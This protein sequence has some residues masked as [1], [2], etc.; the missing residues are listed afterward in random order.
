MEP[1]KRKRMKKCF[2]LLLALILIVSIVAPIDAKSTYP[3]SCALNDEVFSFIREGEGL[4]VPEQVIAKASSKEHA[5]EIAEAYGLIFESYAWGI[6]VF[7]VEDA[8]QAVFHSYRIRREDL[9]VLSLNWIYTTMDD[10]EDIIEEDTRGELR[11]SLSHTGKGHESLQ[12]PFVPLHQ[13][14]L[15]ET[16]ETKVQ[17]Y[18]WQGRFEELQRELSYEAP[19]RVSL[20]LSHWQHDIMD[21]HRAWELSRGEGVIVAVIDTGIDIDHPSFEGRILESSFN[22]HTGEIGLQGVRD[23][24]GHGTHVTG[25]LA[26]A[27]VSPDYIS[28]VAT[29]AYIMSIK[30]NLPGTGYFMTSDLLRSINYAVANGADIINMSL[31][32][33]GWFEYYYHH[34]MH[35]GI[36]NAV[37]NGITVVAAAGNSRFN[38]VSFP[39]AFPEVIA[40]SSVM[41]RGQRPVF[42]RSYSNHGAGLDLSAPGTN[43][44]AAIP[45]GWYEF[46]SGTSMAAP[47][48]AG[49]AALLLSQKLYQNPE[50]RDEFEPFEISQKVR[51][52]LMDGTRQV[53]FGNAYFYGAGI[54]DSYATLRGR[55]A[56]HTVTYRLYPGNEVMVRVSPGG[57]I[58]EPEFVLRTDY[59]FTGWLLD[60]EAFDF[61]SAIHRNIELYAHWEE[62][63]DGMYIAQFPDKN[64]R[65]EVQELLMEIDGVARKDACMIT[66]EDK[67]IL[68]SI[69]GLQF[70]SEI[71]DLEGIHHFTGLTYLELYNMGWINNAGLER[72]DLS[73]NVNLEWF[74]AQNQQN[75][76]S[77]DFSNNPALRGVDVWQS[78]L[79]ELNIRENQAL[80]VLILGHFHDLL[81]VDVSRNP[82]LRILDIGWFQTV[83]LTALDLT[84]NPALER[85]TIGNHSLFELDLSNN[86]ELKA[87][88]IW[89]DEGLIDVDLSNNIH[90][91]YLT[92]FDTTVE[93]LNITYNPRLRLLSVERNNLTN[94]DVSQ[95]LKLT[96]IGASFNYLTTFDVSNNPNLEF[97]YVEV[98][99]LTEMDLSNNPDLVIFYGRYNNLAEIHLPGNSALQVL[100]AANNQLTSLDIS[101]APELSLLYLNNNHIKELDLSQNSRLGMFTELILSVD[102]YG[103]W[104]IVWDGGL[105]VA[106]NRLRRLDIS[107]TS[108]DWGSVLG[109]G[110]YFVGVTLDV[111][112]NYLLAPES[113]VIGW[114]GRRL[115]V[116]SEETDWRG[117]FVFTPQRTREGYHLIFKFYTREDS[118]LE[119]LEDYG[120]EE[121]NGFLMIE[122]PVTPGTPRYTW[123]NQE[124]LDLALGQSH[125]Y[126][127]R[128]ASGF[129]FWGW[130][131]EE[132]LYES[133]RIDEASS[134]R[135]PLLGDECEV[136][137]ILELI[138]KAM[139]CATISSL[140]SSST[141]GKINLFGIWSPWGDVND[142]GTVDGE[143]L[144]LFRRYLQYE[145]LGVEVQMNHRAADVVPDGQLNSTDWELLRQYLQYGPFGVEVVLGR[146]P[147]L[148]NLFTF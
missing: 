39:A 124:L 115:Y 133:R 101:S 111:S 145:P 30:A 25:T 27:R 110:G 130:F 35:D 119:R 11:R 50:L 63:D 96:L 127:E 92:I 22:A 37:N 3:I 106:N 40:V 77:L 32:R 19:H 24:I 54:V 93:T 28:G 72:V 45:G 70:N 143:D 136:E 105:H 142:N 121:R 84:N 82:A 73:Y 46:A 85:L 67:A 120:L 49:T 57:R 126:G 68:A 65:R 88:D 95:N 52:G 47:N 122:V 56:L 80:E 58:I 8:P 51:N 113:C 64:F 147:H 38:Q 90:L 23:D 61:E 89:W 2:T 123:E 36:I 139:T 132:T 75:L 60:G 1:L 103:W 94:L 33:E 15:I 71:I 107:N 86:S 4:I 29:E 114:Q 74:I 148:L 108:P 66:E 20:E 6:A 116:R 117:N 102:D 14:E 104:S 53:G 18:H 109:Y 17:T 21:N 97:L 141:D 100:A 128:G 87:L 99:E 79:L 134:L 31:G 26:G 5:L 146:A 13:G 138:E 62:K 83:R 98:N 144:E 55:D 12:R 48:V 112:G 129:S 81:E 9:P 125:L 42:D 131:T 78:N 135:R 76:Q 10:S 69:E 41:L 140:F 44:L 118:I 43:I 16:A 34:L 59:V 7:L 137:V 91:E